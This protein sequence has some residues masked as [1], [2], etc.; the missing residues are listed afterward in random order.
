M[1]DFDA[2]LARFTAKQDGPK[3][4]KPNPRGLFGKRMPQAKFEALTS[5]L[6]SE[7]KARAARELS[8][9]APREG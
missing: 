1:T 4:S 7:G 6:A 2:K 5:R 8:F 3:M 9:P